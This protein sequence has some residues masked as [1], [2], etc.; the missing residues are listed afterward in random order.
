MHFLRAEPRCALYRGNL[1]CRLI[2]NLF[3]FHGLL[4]SLVGL[5]AV[6]ASMGTGYVLLLL[7][8]VGWN[9][10]FDCQLKAK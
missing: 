6:G 7:P 1:N 9:S 4:S 3:S 5:L 8:T 10:F 2:G